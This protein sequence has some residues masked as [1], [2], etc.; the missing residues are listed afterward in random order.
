MQWFSALIPS[1]PDIQTR[2]HA[3]LDRV[4]GR[5][6][7]PTVEDEP[8]LPYLRAIIKVRMV[9]FIDLEMIIMI[10]PGSRTL[11]QSVL[12]WYPACQQPRFHISRALYT[13]GYCY[14]IEHCTHVAHLNI[15]VHYVTHDLSPVYHT[16]Q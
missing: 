16:P 9:V 2:A 8:H 12:A 7:L 3:E 11:S 1:Y 10:L 13:T 6:R 14:H 15:Y 4:V 5:N